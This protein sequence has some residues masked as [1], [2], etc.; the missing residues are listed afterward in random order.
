M[1]DWILIA[2]LALAALNLLILLWIALF[3][4]DSSVLL[5][6]ALVFSHLSQT[7]PTISGCVTYPI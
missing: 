4:A 1:P 6:I 2:A 5:C 3:I 7:L